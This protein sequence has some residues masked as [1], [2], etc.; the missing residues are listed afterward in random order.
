MQLLEAS[1]SEMPWDFH[2]ADTNFAG[3]GIHKFLVCSLQNSIEG[4]RSGY[5][6]QV[7][8][9]WLEENHPLDSSGE[10]D[11]NGAGSDAGSEFAHMLT[12]ISCCGSTAFQAHLQ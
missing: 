11:Q 5:K 6:Q 7:T 8:P 9:Q 2:T 4:Q 10:D 1:I 12:E 3:S